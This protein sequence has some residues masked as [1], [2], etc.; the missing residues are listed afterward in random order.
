MDNLLL[1]QNPCF[2]KLADFI[3]TYQP[4]L[5]HSAFHRGTHGPFHSSGKHTVCP[6]S[7]EQPNH[8][9]RPFKPVYHC[10][11]N[12]LSVYIHKHTT[13][14]LWIQSRYV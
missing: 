8:V 10:K 4:V 5:T 11:H 3:S 2:C 14:R 9:L 12:G 1:Q 13:T 7:S 6:G